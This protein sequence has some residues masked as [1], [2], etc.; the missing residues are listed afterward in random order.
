MI[1]NVLT[2]DTDLQSKDNIDKSYN[3][4][5]KINFSHLVNQHIPE[6]KRT[7][8]LSKQTDVDDSNLITSRKTLAASEQIEQLNHKGAE[9]A[10]LS[11]QAIVDPSLNDTGEK[12]LNINNIDTFN[13][14]PVSIDKELKSSEQFMTLLYKSDKALTS[15]VT[16]S[17]LNVGEMD[18]ENLSEVDVAIANPLKNQLSLKSGVPILTADIPDNLGNV[19]KSGVHNLSNGD[20]QL[21]SANNM[22]D[23]LI[24]D[25][26]GTKSTQLNE[27]LM[28]LEKMQLN[29]KHHINSDEAKPHASFNTVNNL[30]TNTEKFTANE[31]FTKGS[32]TLNDNTQFT[33]GSETDNTNEQLNSN[34]KVILADL[35]DQKP[36]MKL[37]IRQANQDFLK[38]SDLMTSNKVLPNKENHLE[39]SHTGKSLNQPSDS[40]VVNDS[41]FLQ[42][43]NSKEDSKEEVGSLNRNNHP[44]VDTKSTTS[45][46]QGLPKDL[47]LNNKIVSDSGLYNL[48]QPITEVSQQA[49]IITDKTINSPDILSKQVLK[50]IV[51]P[52]QFV[53]NSDENLIEYFDETLSLDVDNVFSMNKTISDIK[54]SNT[55]SDNANTRFSQDT[56]FQTNQVLQSKQTNEAYLAHQVSETLNHNLASDTA[57]IQKNNVQLQQETIAIFRKDFADAVKDKVLVMI[58]QKL[59]QFDITL[60]PPEFGNMQVRVNLQ[61]EQASVNFVVQ[62]QQAKEALEQNMQK[63]KD[64]LAEQG[65]DVGDANVDQKNQGEQNSQGD[66]FV[67]SESTN[68]NVVSEGEVEQVFSAD[69]FNSPVTA[70]DYYA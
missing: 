48:S 29:S 36:P 57:H 40:E 65:V 4:D 15:T 35:A 49:N 46:P 13:E 38:N 33:K 27:K 31:Q 3:Y 45:K 26:V 55:F 54:P 16:F 53:E 11:D 52:K 41:L 66:S 17:N 9:K 2:Q 32:E 44:S 63:L 59:Q 19:I 61:G 37:S 50:N 62:N 51:E 12:L 18:N 69:L 67:S 68:D 56:Q 7:S 34:K 10:E 5:E 39:N 23:K 24:E 30:Y 64:M 1:T 60:D 70:I 22:S 21:G 43:S 42:H 47:V 20:N 14:A 8:D 6:K 28:P 58:N 25:S